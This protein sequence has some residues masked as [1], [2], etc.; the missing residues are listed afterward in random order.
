MTDKI[1]SCNVFF[2]KKDILVASSARTT[3]GFEIITDPVF[4]LEIPQSP[5]R[6]GEVVLESMKAYRLDAPPPGPDMNE[7]PN[8]L[9]EIAGCRS[10]AQLDR[11]SVNVMVNRFPDFIIA[12]PT[13]RELG[14]GVR[15]LN[16]LA[17]KSETTGEKVGEAVLKAASLS[18]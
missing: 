12:V 2:R 1:A 8:P 13:R 4:K 6:I 3:A 17:I 9:L 14:R 11:S 18:S 16:D 15:H 10:W 5:L 7:M